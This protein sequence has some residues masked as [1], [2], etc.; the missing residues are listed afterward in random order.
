MIFGSTSD[1]TSLTAAQLGQIMFYDGGLGSNF[2]GTG[3]F[4]GSFGEVVPV[5]EPSSIFAGLL[6]F[7]FAGWHLWRKASA[8][9]KC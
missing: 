9:T 4:V 3:Q 8:S 1:S 5:P 7:A 6:T 2:L